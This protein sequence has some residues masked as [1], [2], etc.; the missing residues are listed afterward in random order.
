MAEVRYSFVQNISIFCCSPTKCSEHFDMLLQSHEMFRTFRY[1]LTVPRNVQNISIFCCSPTKCSEHF[2]MWLQS[3]EMFGT[4]R[5]S[6]AVPWNIQNISI[7]CCS[8]T[9]CS[10]HFNILLQ[11]HEISPI[12]FF[13]QLHSDERSSNFISKPIVIQHLWHFA[14]TILWDQLTPKWKNGTQKCH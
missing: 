10:E 13:H 14:P 2:D 5:Y 9:K 8:P 6:V 11:S 1:S 3:H 4:F 7:F 12:L